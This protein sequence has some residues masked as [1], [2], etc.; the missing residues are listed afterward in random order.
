MGYKA[1]CTHIVRD[2]DKPGSKQ[3]K[4]EVVEKVTVLETPPMV[5]IGIVGYIETPRG[6][7]TLATVWAA[8]LSNEV[9]RRFYKNWYRSKHKAF[10]KYAKKWSAE[11]KANTVDKDLARIRKHAQVVRVLAHTQISKLNLRQKKAHLMEIQVNGGSVADKVAFAESLLEKQVAVDTVFAQDDMIDVMGVTKGKGFQGVT[12]RWGTRKL[13]RKTHK[14]LRKVGCIGAWHPERVSRAVPRAGQ[15]GYFHRVEINKK[16]YRIG[17]QQKLG[18]AGTTEFDVTEKSINPLGGFPHYGMITEDFIVLKGNVFGPKKRVITLRKSIV[19]QTSR[20]A[21]EKVK[22]KFIDTSSKFGH[23]R[24]QT[25]QEK[26]L[27]MGV[28]KRDRATNAPATAAAAAAAVAGF[29][30]GAMSR[31]S[32][33]SSSADAS[34][35]EPEAEPPSPD[36]KS[37]WTPSSSF[38]SWSMLI[39]AD[40]G[41]SP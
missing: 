28:M 17:K 26:E 40:S 20:S 7:R 15:M 37:T 21:L 18:T 14:G 25:P 12:K 23:G 30:L 4:K 19:P 8:H 33:S 24:F 22:L 35:A 16:L 13:P 5:V 1:G 39:L 32:S 10:G 36:T 9:K 34:S 38:W 2:L 41:S 31:S 29:G 3:H 6:L 11:Q 27:Y